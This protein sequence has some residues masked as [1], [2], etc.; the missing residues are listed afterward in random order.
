MR[1]EIPIFFTIDDGYAPNMGIAL[2]SMIQ[3]ASRQYQYK[4]HVIHQG[5]S[6]ENQRKIAAL[7]NENFEIL[8]SEMGEKLSGITDREE[9]RLR[10]DYFSL[11]IYFRLFLAD[12]F[13]EYEKAIYV[14]SDIVVPGD[15]SEMY[16]LDLGE[17]IIGACHD[18][19]IEEVPELVNYIENA[20][21]VACQEYINS[22][23]LLLNMKRLRELNFSEK[24]LTLLTTYHVDCIAPDQDYL[25]AMCHGNIFYL[26]KAWDIMPQK[27][28][29]AYQNPKLIHYNLFDK[30]WCYRGIQ[31]EDYFWKYAEET[32]FYEE[33]RRNLLEYSEEQ[34]RHDAQSMNVMIQKADRQPQKE[35][36]FKKLYEEGKEI[37]IC[38]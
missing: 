37:R 18:F 33:V 22:G 38:S 2:Y 31:Y 20:V 4:I 36:T 16:R 9:N 11:T 34:A 8:F 27:G 35:L 15:I 26:D 21:G 1:E 3:N 5:L 29:E 13:P 6:E 10:C 7:G 14:D 25:N 28:K 24:F 19:S 30:P 12:M 17:K 32:C 23:V